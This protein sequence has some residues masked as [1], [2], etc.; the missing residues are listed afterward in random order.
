MMKRIV[1][2]NFSGL[3]QIC[4]ILDIAA[5]TDLEKRLTSG[6]NVY[7]LVKA[8]KRHV[9]YLEVEPEARS[10]EGQKASSTQEVT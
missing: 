2:E 6:P 7:A 5:D 3:R 10:A 9:V 4:G 1:L 8:H